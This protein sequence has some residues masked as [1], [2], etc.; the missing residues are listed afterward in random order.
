MLESIP[1]SNTRTKP[2]GLESKLNF[3]KSCHHGVGAALLQFE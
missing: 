1:K 3:R 2:I